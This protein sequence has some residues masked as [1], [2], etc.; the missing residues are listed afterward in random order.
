MAGD[1][2]LAYKH[3]QAG[4]YLDCIN[5]LAPVMQDSVDLAAMTIYAVSLQRLWRM[6]EAAIIY[7]RIIEL[8]PSN[9]KNFYNRA[10][11]KEAAAD[12]HGA[13][14]DYRQALSMQKDYVAC[15]VNLASILKSLA[16][17]EES[18]QVCTDALKYH[19][20]HPGVLVNYANSLMSSGK[21]FEALN[22]YRK[23]ITLEPSIF[24]ISNYLLC[25]LYLHGNNPSDIYKEHLRVKDFFRKHYK[26]PRPFPHNGEK[27][28]VGYLSADFKRHSV[29]YFLEPII[30]R[31]D[32]KIFEIYCY[33]DT[34]RI[35]NITARFRS[36][37]DKWVDISSMN[38]IDII[39]LIEKD[40]IDI[41]VDLGGHTGRRLDVFAAKPARVQVTY[42]GYPATTGLD[43]IDYRIGDTYTDPE[44]YEQY[45]TEK[46]Y[47]IA[48]SFLCFSPPEEA[49]PLAPSPFRR[50]GYITF[51]SFNAI[52]KISEETLA[53]WCQILIKVPNSRLFL[54]NHS[55][56]DDGV[57]QRL[58][59]RFTKYGIPEHRIDLRPY[60]AQLASHLAVY[61]EID[62]AL[63]TFPYNG[64]TT[65][66]EAL[67]MGVPTIT[68][69][70]RAHL[71]RVGLSIMNNLGLASFVAM[72]SDEY[73]KKA[74]T[75]A[76]DT[77][78][79]DQLH[80]KL[81]DLLANSILCDS[82]SF[83]KKLERF[84]RKIL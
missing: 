15:S 14:A 25:N 82:V 67:W 62:I 53:A 77:F 66:F 73:V 76:S 30:F 31:H 19:P 3:F 46:L 37:S 43:S 20:N 71:S 84:Y 58:M 44:G 45:Y 33:S 2:E 64:T 75:L 8:E 34:K 80:Q 72:T 28:R 40:S 52:Q 78:L 69:A 47:R 4:A 13:I 65:T 38:N 22:M 83:T 81:R 23:A 70:G 21:I 1:R 17:L 5:E 7:D 74:V 27:I 26:S 39:K 61:S 35:D 54:K 41:L 56:A 32:K 68:L 63:D 10:V 42:L 16:Y 49:P 55:M 60:Q 79:V 9:F 36:L 57:R 24:S 12:P 29:A 6:S 18:I 59:E 11:F 50:N 48:D 51:G